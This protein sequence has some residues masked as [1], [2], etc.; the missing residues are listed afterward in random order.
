MRKLKERVTVLTEESTV[1][2]DQV[3]D[4]ALAGAILADRLRKAEG[5]ARA[6]RQRRTPPTTMTTWRA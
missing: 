1:L 6:T 4:L 2:K 3:T 5:T